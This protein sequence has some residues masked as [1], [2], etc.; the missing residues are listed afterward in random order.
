MCY[1]SIE[2]QIVCVE[3]LMQ[4]VKQVP[5]N[6]NTIQYQVVETIRMLREKGLPND[7]LEKYLVDYWKQIEICHWELEDRIKRHDLP[8]LWELLKHLDDIRK[9]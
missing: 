8:Y 7:L 3:N 1:N 4:Y 9:L 6:A 5:V 2:R